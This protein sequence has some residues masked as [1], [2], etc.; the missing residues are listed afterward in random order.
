MSE[1]TDIESEAGAP[2][3]G[4]ELEEETVDGLPVL[5]EIRP[6]ERAPA[7]SFPAVHAAAA[8]A[9]GFVAGAATVAL[10]KRQSA[11]KLA[12]VQRS[13][14]QRAGALLPVV[15]SRTFLVDVYLLAKPGE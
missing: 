12:R 13:G 1:H 5:A 6:I 8:A 15:A 14:P 4:E 7:P 9:T 3:C 11:R 2:V 10:V